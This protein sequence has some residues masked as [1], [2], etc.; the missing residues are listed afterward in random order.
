MDSVA[1]PLVVRPGPPLR[2]SFRAPGDKSVTHRG[3]LFALLAPG[4]TEV[5]DPN[6][7]DDCERTLAAV[8]SLGVAVAR[9][10]HR[11]TFEHHELHAPAAVVDCGNS[12]STL[13]MLAGVL[14]AQPFRTT[15]TGD[16][17]LRL[18]PVARVIEPLRR[19][20]ATLSAEAGDR[21]PP[22][23]IEGARLRGIA[24]RLPIASAQVASAIELAATF[25]DGPTTIEIPGAA[26][27][28]TERMLKA[29][30]V[31]VTVEPLAGGGRRVRIEPGAPTG[32]RRFEVP[33][34]FS[35]AAFFLAAAAATPGAEVT[36]RGLSLNPTRTAFL[37][38]LAGMGAGVTTSPLGIAG[39]EP[40]GDV[41]VTG[42]GRL[43]AFDVPAEWLPRMLDEVPAW[44]IVAAVAE[45]ISRVSG[46]AELRVKESDRLAAIAASLR[47][48]GIEATETPDGVSVRGGRP[49][50]GRVAARGDHRI[51]MAFAVLGT[52]AGGAIEVDDASAITTS[53]PGFAGA[54]ELLGGRLEHAEGGRST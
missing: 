54:L 6:P 36:A 23:V 50:G 27:D 34:D 7:G 14:A 16:D 20:G 47:V 12:G 5:L 21:L 41:T 18:R 45:G 31:G 51:A 2:G 19:M 15:L 37:E 3:Y 52:L 29:S 25:A 42:P 13:R 4:I 26:R 30:G 53:Y 8:R 39:G 22:L 46:A 9:D 11:V 48:L 10:Q 38:V 44:A 35:S 49:G 40:V 33:G 28:H 32:M 17:S 1:R 43:R 24:Y